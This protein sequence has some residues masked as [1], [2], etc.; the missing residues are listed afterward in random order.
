MGAIESILFEYEDKKLIQKNTNYFWVTYK[1]FNDKEKEIIRIPVD[2]KRKTIKAVD[3]CL[4]LIIGMFEIYKQKPRYKY[5]TYI[6][7]KYNINPCNCGIK[8]CVSSMIVDEYEF[9]HVENFILEY[10][11][12]GINIVKKFQVVKL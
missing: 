1:N 7:F 3:P 5:E 12:Q 11:Q 4:P 8:D 2:V 10:N 9:S 6:N